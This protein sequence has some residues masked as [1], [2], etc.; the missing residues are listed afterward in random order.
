TA[1]CPV[2]ERFDQRI[3]AVRFQASSPSCRMDSPARLGASLGIV[4]RLGWGCGLPVLHEQRYEKGDSIRDAECLSAGS[5]TAIC[6]SARRETGGGRIWLYEDP[7]WVAPDRG[8]NE[9]RNPG[10]RFGRV[11][12]Q[13]LF[14]SRWATV[15]RCA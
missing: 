14:L 8:S 9:S 6:R 3:E 5:T 10:A 15:L 1:A 2:R 13:F 12:S 11:V 4:A 7:R